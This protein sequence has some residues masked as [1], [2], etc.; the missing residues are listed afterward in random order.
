MDIK[1]YESLEEA[2][3]DWQ[4]V[5]K[6]NFHYPFQSWWYLNLFTE[7]FAK[8]ENL[9]ILKIFKD[10]T[11]FAL[12]AFEIIGETVTFLGTKDV[13]ENPEN[14]QDITDFG[15]LLYSS[16]GKENANKIWENLISYFKQNGIE[17][18][19]LSYIRE[20]SPTFSI[21]KEEFDIKKQETSPFII[22]PA[23]WDEYLSTLERKERHE[24]KR[25][26]NR[27]ERET[28]FHLCK[29]QTIQTDFSNFIR[30]HKLS[31]PNKEKFM[32]K[33]MEGFFWDMV[34]CDKSDWEI[35]FC[36]LFIDNMQV[37]SVMAFMNR[38]H[39]LLYNSGFD[40][41]YAYYSVGLLVKAFLLKKSIEQKK[42]IY[43]FLR[44]NERYKYDMG[45]KDLPLFQVIIS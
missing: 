1:K 37:A 41:G 30:L 7:H 40:P 25:K 10:E 14:V 6:E 38:T 4:K 5:E 29:D 33:E 45:A 26:I 44:G 3:T 11:I 22:L 23:T 2:K 32:T 12:G 8:N 15:D 16:K 28:A 24:L 36:S 42:Q 34:T 39:T 13:S 27:L 43:D 17:K 35:H 20:D 19:K 18:F 21:F 9:R 31:D